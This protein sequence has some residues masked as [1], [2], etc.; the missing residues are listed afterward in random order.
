MKSVLISA[1][2][3]FVSSQV[4]ATGVPVKPEVLPVV[5][6]QGQGQDQ[7]QLQTQKQDQDQKQLQSQK[8]VSKAA[9]AANST[10]SANSGS[11]SNSNQSLDS[12]QSLNITE[13][14]QAP[15]MFAGH[16]DTTAFCVRS[17]GAT[18]SIPGGGVGI[19]LP[20]RDKDCRLAQAA[21]SEYAKGNFTASIKLRCEI[22]FYK[23]T[24]G[25]TC[26]TSLDNQEY[27]LPPVQ[28]LEINVN[29]KDES[30][31]EEK[32]EKA[33]KQCVAK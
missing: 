18:L 28:P 16:S 15:S 12:N 5:V 3:A 8:A 26:Y 31:C 14:R 24:F 30:Q 7:K 22:S 17:G 33:F 25:E 13:K 21:D 9:A 32:V 11:T 23:Q 27:Y 29:V 4:L 10:A 2:A 20:I 1:V 19:N 6:N